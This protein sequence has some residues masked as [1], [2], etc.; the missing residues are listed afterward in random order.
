M[1]AA[2]SHFGR[3]ADGIGG[4]DEGYEHRAPSGTD[5]G[6]RW[7]MS[8]AERT[9]LELWIEPGSEP[10]T[11]WLAHPGGERQAFGGWV[12]LTAAIET[13]RLELAGAVN[14]SGNG[15]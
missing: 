11:G 1:S 6:E 13:A 3:P 10:I 2:Q 15:H 8:F 5:Q 4:K 9:P 7:L 12:E 14:G